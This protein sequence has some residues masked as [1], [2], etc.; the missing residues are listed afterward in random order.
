MRFFS[1]FSNRD[2]YVVP[3]EL[4]THPDAKNVFLPDLSHSQY[5]VSPKVFQLVASCLTRPDV[6][7]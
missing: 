1:I 2:V 7:N 6:R 5:L 4:M 3:A